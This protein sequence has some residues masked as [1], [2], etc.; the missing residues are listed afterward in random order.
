MLGEQS[1]VVLK[2]FLLNYEMERS[3]N[4]CITMKKTFKKLDILNIHR[5]IFIYKKEP[6]LQCLQ[7][8]TMKCSV[9]IC[10]TKKE[11]SKTICIY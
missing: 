7:N 2:S 5:T 9:Y 1:I 10:I 8:D 6:Q 4:I 3:F 11:N